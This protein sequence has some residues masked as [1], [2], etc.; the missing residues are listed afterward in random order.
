MEQEGRDIQHSGQQKFPQI[1]SNYAEPAPLVIN[2][3]HGEKNHLVG[4]GGTTTKE[5]QTKQ[6]A[7]DRCK[8]FLGLKTSQENVNRSR[9][10]SVERSFILKSTREEEKKLNL[11][12]RSKSM[13]ITKRSSLYNKPKTD[14]SFF[15]ENNSYPFTSKDEYIRKWQQDSFMSERKKSNHAFYS[16]YFPTEKLKFLPEDSVDSLHSD[17]DI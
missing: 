12:K 15:I 4:T 9:A 16:I 5:R 1:Y 13:N 2:Q 14:T 11:I 3:Q 10:K 6:T 8:S 17:A 7:L